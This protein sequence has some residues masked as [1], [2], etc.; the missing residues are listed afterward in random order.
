VVAAVVVVM[1]DSP[2]QAASATSGATATAT[3]VLR[4]AARVV[5]ER[6]GRAAEF[7]FMTAPA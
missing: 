7:V 4:S 6:R 1:G 5:A 3:A 2:E